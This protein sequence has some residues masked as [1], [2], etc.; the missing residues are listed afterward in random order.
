MNRLYLTLLGSIGLWRRPTEILSNNIFFM[1]FAKVLMLYL[2][3]IL[4]WL[5]SSNSSFSSSLL[6]LLTSISFISFISS[7]SS[8]SAVS[9]LTDSFLTSIF[10]SKLS[11]FLFLSDSKEPLLFLYFSRMNPFLCYF[12]F[13]FSVR[14]Y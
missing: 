11:L 6:T 1:H 13:L 10:T 14:L 2:L 9:F 12:I 4:S 7:I 8:V 3:F 5:S